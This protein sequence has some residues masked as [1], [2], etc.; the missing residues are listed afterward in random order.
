M[1]RLTTI[2]SPEINFKFGDTGTE[3][4]LKALDDHS[5]RRFKDETSELKIKNTE[6][7]V[8]SVPVIAKGSNII[9]DTD[10]LQ[11]IPAGQYDV[12]LWVTNKDQ[13]TVIYPDEG[14]LKL[15]INKNSTMADGKLVSSFTL[16][17]IE[18]KVDKITKELSDKI[19][20]QLKKLTGLNLHDYYTKEQVDEKIPAINLDTSKRVLSI[21][22]IGI[23]IPDTVDL[24]AYAKTSSVPAISYDSTKRVINLNGQEIDLSDHI[25]LSSFYNKGDIDNMFKQTAANAK[26]VLNDYLTAKD[27]TSRFAEKKEVPSVQ[28]DVEGRTLAVNGTSLNIPDK[29]DLTPYV[30]GEQLE[31]YAKKEEVPQI[32]LNVDERKIVLNGKTINIPDDVDLSGYVTKTEL[33]QVVYDAKARTLSIDGQQVEIPASLDMSE[34]LTK[35]EVD[36]KLA[37]VKSDMA[38]LTKKT[39]DIITTDYGT[40]VRRT[41]TSF[42]TAHP[43]A[44]SINELVFVFDNGA[45]MHWD[46]KVN[47]DPMI[48]VG[49]NGWWNANTGDVDNNGRVLNQL[50][51][52]FLL[53]NYGVD[54]PREKELSHYKSSCFVN[55]V[56]CS[57]VNPYQDSN[58]Y[59]WG[60]AHF[61]S[62]AAD[63]TPGERNLIKCWYEVGL[64]SD[65]DLSACNVVKQEG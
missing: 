33:P 62:S 30:K 47:A 50:L 37:N 4:V 55:W 34:Y 3:I 59:I 58:R 46:A 1:R 48:L 14:F 15:N 41:P 44:K 27:A 45:E 13:E 28:L 26:A 31:A 21:N 6:A 42:R 8:K 60:D 19:D 57:V 12:E 43:N 40:F 52:Q 53:G 54:A 39:A 61:T 32:S 49:Q 17:D 38:K 56:Y 7:F 22:G 5:V 20:V 9:L 18:K 29:V 23:N 16:A 64:L 51:A 11:E 35:D 25:D 10:S 2:N 65:E 63:V 36:N 24:S